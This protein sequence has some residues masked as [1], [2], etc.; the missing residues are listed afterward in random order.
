MPERWRFTRH[1][2]ERMKEMKLDRREVQA[3]LKSPEATYRGGLQHPPGRIVMLKGRIAVVCQ[4]GTREVVTV[5]W[6]GEE[7]RA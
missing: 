1:A 6:R 3:A 2:R 5:L 4:I 7:G